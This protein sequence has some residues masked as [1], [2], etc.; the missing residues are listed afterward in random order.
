MTGE[1]NSVGPYRNGFVLLIGA[2]FVF[3]MWF[4]TTLPLSGDEA[5]HWEWSR[6]PA[7]GY[8]DHPG[9]TA[10]LILLFTRL[11]G[12]STEL[13]VRLPALVMLTGS[14]VAAFLLA[15][16]IAAQKVGAAA[17]DKAGFLAG[18][19]VSTVPLFAV[20]SLYISTDP[21]AIFFNLLS[22]Y[23]FHRAFS[24][25]RWADWIAAG[26]VL[27]LA[28]MSK[29]LSFLI[30]P[31]LGAFA[32]ASPADRKWLVRPQA[33]VAGLCALL[34]F[35]PFLWWNATHD[36]ATFK[37]NFVYRQADRSFAPGFALE[38]LG[39]QALAL[40][41]VVCLC[42]LGCLWKAFRR[43][44]QERDRDALYLG[45]CSAVP[46][47]YFLYVSL[48]RRVGAHWPASGWLALLVC[49][50]IEWAR[51][52]PGERD[53]AARRWM[54]AALSVAVL[55]TAVLHGVIHI[56]PG[57]VQTNWRYAASP[58]RISASKQAERFG[59]RE[60]GQEV[61]RRRDEMAS[62]RV[63]RGLPPDEPPGKGVFVICGE[64]GLAAATAFYT[65]SQMSTHLWAAR[66]T[67]GENYRF[68][69]DFATLKGQD[70]LYVSKRE[71]G[72]LAA[73]A[74][75]GKRFREVGDVERLPVKVKGQEVRSFFFIRC[76]GF[77]G[78]TPDFRAPAS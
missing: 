45:L 24:E 22:V 40:S 41:P 56:P 38:F 26:V 69:D 20:F 36:W 12:R 64:Y 43:W 59:W 19:L 4:S 74:T 10:Y 49:L 14:A 5:Y 77:D 48:Q 67:H 3:R 23:L 15:R 11:L 33:Y 65:P 39:G 42:A 78:R 75:L 9:L 72:A 34:V 21:P 30:V 29:F 60:L 16:R 1:K 44:R 47:A 55:M 50:G 57:W 46:L 66:R 35:S 53:R 25:G 70:G 18:L 71:D 27:G 6:H 68:W 37:F 7:F 58:N 52:E 76:L 32:L 54:T 17:G 73:K 61:E 51:L 31:A 2:V 8:Y 28:L 63:A 13:T 62:A